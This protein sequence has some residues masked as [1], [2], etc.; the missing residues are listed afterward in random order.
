MIDIPPNSLPPSSLRPAPS[1]HP[2]Q[3]QMLDPE[4]IQQART[5]GYRM[6]I[7]EI[8]G[9]AHRLYKAE[10]ELLESVG[11]DM[12]P[13][14]VHFYGEQVVRCQHQQAYVASLLRMLEDRQ[15]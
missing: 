11:K 13:S 12:H 6:A 14:L 3:D 8:Q 9:E 5:H 1:P 2:V 15:P 10:R 4:M 7:A